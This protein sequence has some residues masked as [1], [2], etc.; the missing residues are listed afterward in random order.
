MK[1]RSRIFA[2]IAAT[3]AMGLGVTAPALAETNQTLE[4][5]NV[6]LGKCL[7]VG[8]PTNAWVTLEDCTGA[9][10]QQWER[11]PV[12]GDKVI[13]RNLGDRGCVKGMNNLARFECDDEDVQQYWVLA[14]DQLKNAG[15]GQVADSYLYDGFGVILQNPSGSDYQRWQFTVTGTTPAPPADTSG[16]VV[17][18]K[19]VS[20]RKCAVATGTA[21]RLADCAGAVEQK[22]QRV[23]LGGGVVQ[24]RN[25]ASGTCL[26][27]GTFGLPRVDLV[28]A[29][30]SADPAQQWRVEPD[31]I[32]TFR[33]RN[34][35]GG[36]YLTPRGSSN[37]ITTYE[38]TS[39]ANWQKWSLTI[40]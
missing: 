34:V 35:A 33:V 16:K 23:E 7:S 26:R 13:L 3:I 30:A 9:K 5:K 19:S 10:T 32:G 20:E 18:L 37:D 8:A 38:R 15:T 24:L 1:S 22:F 28:T 6:V 27:T 25:L 11:I 36:T 29:C 40:A 14:G 2:V 12:D 31:L 21:V 4:I 39:L 17:Q